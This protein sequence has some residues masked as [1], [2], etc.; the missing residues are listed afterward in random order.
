M[1]PKPTAAQRRQAALR[2][3][4]D[5]QLTALGEPSYSG[6]DRPALVLE[7]C[8]AAVLRAGDAGTEPVRAAV[9]AA[10]RGT[11]AE[12][13]ERAPGHSLEV[14][15][16]PFGAVQ[17]LEGPRHTRGTPPGV[18]ETGPTTWLALAMGRITWEEAVAGHRVTASG[19]RADLTALLPL[20]PP[21]AGH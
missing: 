16:P 6:P 8:A 3:A 11:L 15:V 18:V 1:S 13:A 4:L 10:V 12:L 20:W 17:C 7:A 5:D 9:R 2:T 19:V 14:R 21:R